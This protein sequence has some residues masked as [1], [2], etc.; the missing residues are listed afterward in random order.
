MS[1][2]PEHH[3]FYQYLHHAIYDLTSLSTVKIIAQMVHE[4]C[5]RKSQGFDIFNMLNSNS[6]EE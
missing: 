2:Q 5:G 3:M 4:F 6:T 1:S